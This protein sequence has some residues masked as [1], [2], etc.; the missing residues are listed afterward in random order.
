VSHLPPHIAARRAERQAQLR[1]RRLTLA[2]LAGAAALIAVAV[3][4]AASGGRSSTSASRPAPTVAAPAAP[5]KA[6]PAAAPLASQ[7]GSAAV[8]RLARLGLPVFC[9]GPHGRALAFTFDDGP[10]PYTHFAIKKLRQAGQSATFFT[11]GRSIDNFPGWLQR[12]EP[13]AAIGDHTLTHPLLTE[14]APAEIERQIGQT[15]SQ[16]ESVI[17][18]PVQLFR[19]PYGAHN[20][21]VDGIVRRLGMLEIIWDVDSADSLGAN[22]AGIIRNVEAGMRPGAIILMHENRG[23]TIR[24]LTTILP[25][26]HR[27]G[28]RSV[29]LPELLA[30][31]P[32]SR[33]QLEAGGRGCGGTLAHG[34]G[35]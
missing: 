20:A 7:A 30:S 34:N 22:Y 12:E 31:D 26:L 15:R 14:L 5:E 6:R 35:G 4:L 10:G 29:T 3:A 18:R 16:I 25:E 1:R 23:Q 8:T 11:V 32:P 27:R 9:A 21:V 2:M 28:L 13:L 19:P 24:A 33:A 17:G